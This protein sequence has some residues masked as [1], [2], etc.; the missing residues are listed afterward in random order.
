MYFLFHL[1]YRLLDVTKSIVVLV[2]IINDVYGMN[3]QMLF[4]SKKGKFSLASKNPKVMLLFFF[5]KQRKQC[6]LQDDVQLF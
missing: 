3:Y 4:G 1:F 5:F 6:V 2:S